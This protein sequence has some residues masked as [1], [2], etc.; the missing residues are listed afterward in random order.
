MTDD[1]ARVDIQSVNPYEA[2]SEHVESRPTT[3]D[4]P[5]AVAAPRAKRLLAVMVDSLLTVTPALPGF[6]FL[7]FTP[8]PEDLHVGH[9]MLLASLLGVLAVYA[10]QCRLIA[11]TGQSLAKRWL[12]LRIVRTSGEPP[13]FLHGVVLRYLVFD[14]LCIIPIVWVVLRVADGVALFGASARTLR[15]RLADT[16]VV[17]V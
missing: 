17:E 2:P 6:L 9:W 15:D 11:N 12:R 7:A 13:G 8:G 1:G 14:A 3:L 16:R 4:A 10:Y 5:K